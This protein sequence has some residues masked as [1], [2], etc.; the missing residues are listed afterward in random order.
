[1]AILSR[2]LLGSVTR[3]GCRFLLGR[4][5]PL[6]RATGERS[7]SLRPL[8]RAWAS[9]SRQLRASGHRASG[10]RA[11]IQLFLSRSHFGHRA[12]TQLF[13]PRQYNPSPPPPTHRD[14]T[15][16]QLGSCCFLDAR[17]PFR[18]SHNTSVRWRDFGPFFS[19]PA[20][21]QSSGWVNKVL[22]NL[23]FGLWKW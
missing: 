18:L 6:L 13:F 2:A 22:W 19:M 16:L 17:C 20:R 7:P 8:S 23:Y 15:P 3:I 4:V 9:V 14:H 1:M 21:C 5:S 10:H 11:S 12:S